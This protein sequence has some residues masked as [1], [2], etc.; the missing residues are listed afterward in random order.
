MQQNPEIGAQIVAPVGL[1]AA[2][3][4]IA[5]IIRHHHERFD[6]SGYPYGLSGSSIPIGSRI[7]AVADTYSALMQNRPYRPGTTPEQALTEIRSCSGS[8][9]D[10]AIVATFC[11]IVERGMLEPGLFTA[12][13]TA[14]ARALEEYLQL[15]TA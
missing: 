2:P 14:V 3:G 12:P 7:I 8:Q 4:G 13:S 1:C 15:D 9:F 10:P 5:D 6:G 11:S